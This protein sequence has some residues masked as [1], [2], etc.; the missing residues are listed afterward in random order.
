MEREDSP[1]SAQRPWDRA[2]CVHDGAMEEPK[3]MFVH[4]SS[5]EP[6]RRGLLNVPTCRCFVTS[7]PG[8][9]KAC[10]VAMR[11]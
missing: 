1:I 10:E 9:K 6:D 5:R 2:A 8:S 7:A 11:G 3:N 4:V